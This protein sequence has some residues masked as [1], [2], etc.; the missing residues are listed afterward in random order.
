MK[1]KEEEIDDESISVTTNMNHTEVVS[2][3]CDDLSDDP[4]SDSNYD[5]T[6]LIANACHDEVTAQ[7]AAAG[8]IS[9]M[10]KATT[11][12]RSLTYFIPSDH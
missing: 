6:D 5:D 12:S 3:D 2:G 8:K 4:D 9:G 7:L 11:A 1:P 10:A